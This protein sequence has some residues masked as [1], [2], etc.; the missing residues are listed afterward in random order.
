MHEAK[1]QN[2][3]NKFR[4]PESECRNRKSFNCSWLCRY[5]TFDQR[6]WR[7]VDKTPTCWNWIG[8]VSNRGYGLLH[9][10]DKMKKCNRIVWIITNGEIPKGIHVLHKCDNTLCVRPSHLFL[11]THT[12]NMRD[13]IKKG[14]GNKARGERVTNSKLTES[15]VLHMRKLDSCGHASSQLSRKFGVAYNTVRH[16]VTR[17]TWKHI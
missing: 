2:C 8:P 13:C 7:R 1:C 5:G 15:Q 12:D 11:G 17:G 6:F 16:V 14:R 9:H 10:V 3:K 4:V